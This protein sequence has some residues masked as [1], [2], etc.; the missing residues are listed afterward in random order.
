MPAVID[1]RR[2]GDAQLAEHLADE[3]ERGEGRLVA[4]DVELGPGAGIG[5]LL[6][7]EGHILLK[8]AATIGQGNARGPSTA[9]ATL[10][11]RHRRRRR[12]RRA[13]RGA[14]RRARQ[15]GRGHRLAQDAGRDDARAAQ[16]RRAADPRAARGGDRRRSRR[17]RRRWRTRSST[18]G[19][20]P[21]GSTCRCPSRETPR[22]SVHPGQPGDGRAGRDFRRPGLRGRRRARDR[23]RLAQFHRAQHSRDASGAGDARHLLH[24]RARSRA[25][26][27][28]HPHLAGADPHD[29][30]RASRRS[31]SSRRAASIAATATPPTRRCS[32][33]SRGW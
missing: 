21:S 8:P 30:E 25:A 2:M 24:R 18:G 22:G 6:A 16:Q 12:P 33:R 27:A 4:G 11:E 31:A 5:G 20:R 10:R 15:G 19:W 13:R 28:A 26:R 29:D 9:A 14:R 1:P 17:A 3:V 23:G 7:F 32:T